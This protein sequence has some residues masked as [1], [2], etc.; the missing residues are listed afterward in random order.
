MG[1]SLK[2]EEGKKPAPSSVGEKDPVQKIF[3]DRVPAQGVVATHLFPFTVVYPQ[4]E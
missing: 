2:V 1:T 4:C 3:G